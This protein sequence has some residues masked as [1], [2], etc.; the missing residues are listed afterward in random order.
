MKTIGEILFKSEARGY[1]T[2]DEINSLNR[3]KEDAVYKISG[4]IGSKLNAERGAESVPGVYDSIIKDFRAK[5]VNDFEGAV[6]K[7]YTPVMTALPE[8]TNPYRSI[9]ADEFDLKNSFNEK[10]RVMGENMYNKKEKEEKIKSKIRET[11][12]EPVLFNTGT[13][14]PNKIN[15]LTN[16]VY[17]NIKNE[18]IVLTGNPEYLKNITKNVLKNIRK[19]KSLEYVLGLNK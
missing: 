9:L 3:N 18:K 15:E 2:K 16:Q 12:Q 1:M 13:L 17:N 4:R 11:I 10:I 5:A 19:E 6:N 8:K 7:F 14:N